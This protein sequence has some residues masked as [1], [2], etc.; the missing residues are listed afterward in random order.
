[1][2]ADPL[3]TAPNLNHLWARLLVEELVRCGV[4][5]FVVGSGSRSTP[6]AV[7]AGAHPGTAVTV[8]VD[9]R[10]GAFA[11]LGWARATGCPAALVTT[12]GT[13]VANAMPAAVEADAEGVPLLLLTADR[14]PELRETGANQTVRQ[15]G[16]FDGV[17]RWSFD[18][19]VPTADIPLAFVLTTAAQAVYRSRHPAGPVHLNLP[20]REPLAP[21]PDGADVPALLALVEDWIG[22]DGPYTRYVPPVTAPAPDTLQPLLDRWVGVERGLVVLGKTDDPAAAPAAARLASALGWPLLPDL[23]SGGRLGTAG[24]TAAPHYDLALASEAF[25]EAHRPEAVLH[26]GRRATSKRLLQHVGAARPASYAVVR[27][28]AAR[29]DP[30]HSVTH[31][32]QSDVPAFCEAAMAVL[33]PPVHR[34]SSWQTAWQDASAAVAEALAAAFEDDALSEPRLAG[35]VTSLT[36]AGWGLVAAASMPVRDL[37]AFAVASGP[38]LRVTANRGASGID[39]TVATAAG[40]ARGLGGPAVLLLGDLALLH[41]LNGLALLQDGPPVVVVVVNNDGGGIFHFLP[42][43]PGAGEGA[44]PDAVFEPLFGTPHGLGFEPAARMF[45][46]GY[47]RPETASAFAADFRVAV[48]SGRSALIEVRTDRRENRALHHELGTRCARAVEQALGL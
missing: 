44:L 41:D 28:D 14:P 47:A 33:D 46:L 17:A 22:T 9:E 38:S 19:P 34:P 31:R 42:V 11:A 30:T 5:A 40:Y 15:P 48:E 29:F 27:P 10:G 4:T 12:S 20:F 43:A 3:R 45:G 21:R 36:P 37:D 25:R 39:G 26:L 1:M 23:A 8:H 32:V 16:F 35:L 13:A 6:L 2:A 24:P 7:A 18:L